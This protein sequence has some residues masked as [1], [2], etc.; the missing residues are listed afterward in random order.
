M[1]EQEFLEKMQVD[2]LDA[3]SQI[4]LNQ[5]L[6]DIE[7]WDSLAFVNFLVFAKTSGKNITRQ[8]I[9]AALTVSDLY[10]FVK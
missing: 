1:T 7:E 5:S 3:E 10:E 6:A 2:I 9:Q 4:T 8:Q